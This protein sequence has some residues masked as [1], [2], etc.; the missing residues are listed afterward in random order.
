MSAAIEAARTEGLAVLRAMQPTRREVDD[1]RAR[2]ERYR[3]TEAPDDPYIWL[4]CSYALQAVLEG[5]Y[6]VGAVVTQDG[7]V[8]AR[9][10]NHLLRPYVRTDRHAEMEALTELEERFR[11]LD[12]VSGCALYSSLECCPMC[13]VRIVNTG[14]RLVRYAASDPEC[15]VIERWDGMPPYWRR[16][17]ERR[18]PPQRFERARCA[19]ELIEAAGAIFAI[20]EAENS[21]RVA[22]R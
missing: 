20:N 14:L 13:A 16:M 5:N 7:A 12:S 22:Q 15:G 1:W 8:I 10:Y 19:P 21:Q 11:D 4:S 9:G 17:M 3:F 6:G 18:T 2:L